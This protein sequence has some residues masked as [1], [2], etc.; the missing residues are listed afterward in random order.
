[1]KKTFNKKERLKSKKAIEALLKTRFHK[2]VY[3]IKV[4]VDSELYPSGQVKFMVMVPK[5]KIRSSV[6]RTRTK[7]IL[8]EIWRLNKLPLNTFSR[9]KNLRINVGFLF[10]E[11]EPPVFSELN[12]KMGLVMSYIFSVAEK[13]K[14]FVG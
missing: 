8:R 12:D 3:P 7:R 14:Q 11:R 2:S 1:M 4:F 10:L 13:N 9:E 6:K 5:K